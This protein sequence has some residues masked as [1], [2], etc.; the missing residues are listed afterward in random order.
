MEAGEVATRG[1][2]VPGRDTPPGLQPV[3]QPF[4]GVPFLVQL[5]VVP[6]RPS[7][8]PTL[9]FRFAAWSTFSG[10]T[11]LILRLRR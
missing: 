4:D 2:V 3:D 5:G 7:P 9:L 10:M 6:D 11:A 8:C 1:L